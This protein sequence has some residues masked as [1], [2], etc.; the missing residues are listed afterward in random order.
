[1]SVVLVPVLKREPFASQRALLF[2]TIAVDSARW[3]GAR[4]PSSCSQ[5]F[6]YYISGGFRSRAHRDGQWS[7]RPSWGS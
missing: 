5:A 2:R 1:L 3:C 6:R 7:W 4:S